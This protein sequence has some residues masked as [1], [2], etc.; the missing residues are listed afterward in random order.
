MNL[1]HRFN[2]FRLRREFT[3][4]PLIH[5]DQRTVHVC[6]TSSPG[7]AY[8]GNQFHQYSHRSITFAMMLRRH[9]I[10][11]QKYT[12]RNWFMSSWYP[13]CSSTS[14]VH[15]KSDDSLND[16]VAVTFISS[17]TFFVV[18]KL[19]N[20]LLYSSETIFIT[21]VEKELITTRDILHFP[22]C[23]KG[24]VYSVTSQ[25]LHLLYLCIDLRQ[26]ALRPAD[27]T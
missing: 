16:Q 15:I 13:L 24:Y 20:H 9:H 1:P 11:D 26:E 2:C 3:T 6:I 10:D 18:F 19:T 21:I 14:E 22:A 5:I 4:S 7:D 27:S 8:F 12:T 25:F 23:H 17:C